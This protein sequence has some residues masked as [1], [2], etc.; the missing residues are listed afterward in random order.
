MEE[1][2]VVVAMVVEE[3]KVVDIEIHS[4]QRALT[5]IFNSQGLNPL[6]DRILHD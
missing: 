3:A 5:S 1:A 2:A 6:N 4:A